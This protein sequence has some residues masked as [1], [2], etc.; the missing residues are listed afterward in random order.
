[1]MPAV[2]RAVANSRRRSSGRGRGGLAAN[3][4]RGHV[5]SECSNAIEIMGDPVDSHDR[6][7]TVPLRDL[8]LAPR[9]GVGCWRAMVGERERE[10]VRSRLHG[11]QRGS[12]VRG[13]VDESAIC[14]PTATTPLVP[15][16]GERR[17]DCRVASL[18]DGRPQGPSARNRASVVPERPRPP[19]PSLESNTSSTSSAKLRRPSRAPP[20]APAALMGRAYVC[21]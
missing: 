18:G 11:G 4:A 10:R 9:R 21:H 16:A 1:M 12:A 15:T 17:Q 6:L 13:G 14:R 20:P 19:A 5:I 3:S 2:T 7:T 8:A